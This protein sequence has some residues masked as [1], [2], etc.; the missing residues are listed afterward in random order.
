[1]SRKNFLPS[2]FVNFLFGA[3]TQTSCRASGRGNRSSLSL[4]S[5][6]VL[7]CLIITASADKSGGRGRTKFVRVHALLL[8][9]STTEH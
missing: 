5:K 8:D 3:T 7:L 9:R 4:G 6:F 2:K 1:V